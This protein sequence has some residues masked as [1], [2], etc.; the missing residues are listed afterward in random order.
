M[1]VGLGSLWAIIALNN[2]WIGEFRAKFESEPE[3]L[4][5]H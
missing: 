1:V 3:Q 5:A 2:E 4:L